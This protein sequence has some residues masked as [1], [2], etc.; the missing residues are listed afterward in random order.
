MVENRIIEFKDSEGMR[1]SRVINGVHYVFDMVYSYT[2]TLGENVKGRLLVDRY[3][4]V[5]EEWHTTHFIPAN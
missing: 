3:H 4:P 5:M 2:N 1:W